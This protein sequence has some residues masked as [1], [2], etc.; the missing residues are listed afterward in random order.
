MNEQLKPH[1]INLLFEEYKLL[2]FIWKMMTYGVNMERLDVKNHDVVC[3][4]IGFPEDNT[5]E[6]NLGEIDYENPPENFFCRDWLS[7][8][9]ADLEMELSENREVLLSENGLQ[10]KEGNDEAIVRQAISDHVE[11]LFTEYNKLN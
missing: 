3:D 7:N 10:I 11:W 8:T 5:L 2:S 4:M 6:F 9:F 1:F